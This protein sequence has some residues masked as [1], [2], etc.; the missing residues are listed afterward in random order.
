MINNYTLYVGNT[1]SCC[2]KVEDYIKQYNLDIKVVNIDNEDCHLPFQLIIVPALLNGD[3]L[4]AYGPDI[5]KHL[6]GMNSQ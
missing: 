5:L 1:C 2:D 3:E 4:V 6:E